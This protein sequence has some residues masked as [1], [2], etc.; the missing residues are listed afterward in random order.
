MLC[1]VSYTN[2]LFI[3]FYL[4]L[5]ALFF[6]FKKTVILTIFYESTSF[7]CQYITF[8]FINII[9]LLFLSHNLSSWSSHLMK[10]MHL[11]VEGPDFGLY[12]GFYF[13]PFGQELPIYSDWHVKQPAT[14]CCGFICRLGAGRCAFDELKIIHLNCVL[15]R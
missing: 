5:F 2:L 6:P 11:L 9:L 1:H 12:F 7:S 14:I 3:Q 15:D 10:L 4:I 8:I 13:G